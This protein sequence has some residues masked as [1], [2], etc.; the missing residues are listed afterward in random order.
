[1]N[2]LFS[3][4]EWIIW[5]FYRDGYVGGELVVIVMLDRVEVIINRG[6]LCLEGY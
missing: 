2:M 3:W 6:L 4:D 1:M 5:G